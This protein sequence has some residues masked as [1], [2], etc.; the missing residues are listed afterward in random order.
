MASH[1]RETR[2]LPSELFPRE[3][4]DVSSEDY[5]NRSSS[6]NNNG[7]SIMVSPKGLR[8]WESNFSFS[9]SASSSWSEFS[10]PLGSELES[11]SE[12]TEG[13][14][15]DQELFISELTR[16]M[17][18]YMLQDDDD[19]DDDNN[20]HNN[21][22]SNQDP[23]GSVSSYV[24]E[25]SEIPKAGDHTNLD[26]SKFRSG[27]ASYHN[28]QGF[29]NKSDSLA[30][31]SA[32]V[33]TPNTGIHPDDYSTDDQ[34][35]PVQIYQLKNQPHMRKQGSSGGKRVK[36]TES[37]QQQLLQQKEQ[38]GKGKAWRH[39]HA[40][41]PSVPLLPTPPVAGS[42]MRAI[43]LGGSE[44]SGSSGTGVFLPTGTYSKPE[45]KRKSGTSFLHAFTV[46]L[47]LSLLIL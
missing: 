33:K 40:K 43:F 4:H 46:S 3:D 10:S 21:I 24:P 22:N 36:A 11:T 37:N 45:P 9:G 35:P 20:S 41:K 39:G 17:A 14:E 1:E 16:Q 28:S 27:S 30:S 19:D 8:S 7:I 18:E 5:N 23:E 26:W 34:F 31:D 29:M 2:L 12:S 13:E 44:R 25:N 38:Q 47:S 15:D 42:G 32:S 6:S